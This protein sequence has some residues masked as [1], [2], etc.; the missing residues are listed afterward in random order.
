MLRFKMLLKEKKEHKTGSY[1]QIAQLH[2]EDIPLLNEPCI[3]VPLL[4]LTNT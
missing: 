3:L 4:C 2:R 1:I